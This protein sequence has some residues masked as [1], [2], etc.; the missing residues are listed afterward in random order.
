ML[1]IV[2]GS[3]CALDKNGRFKRP[4]VGAIV[5]ILVVGVSLSAVY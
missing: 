1:W 5:N 2:I 3:F 4:E